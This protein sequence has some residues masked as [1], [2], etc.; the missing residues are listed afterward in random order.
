MRHPLGILC[1]IYAFGCA[2]LAE[3]LST[4]QPA[5]ETMA[6][7]AGIQLPKRPWHMVDLYWEFEKSTTNFESLS[8]DV[9]IDRDIPSTCN[10]YVAPIGLTRINGLDCYGGLQS[11]IT[12]W[13]SKTNQ[14]RHCGGKGAIF[15]RW[16]HDKKTRLSLDYV[17]M[18][19]NGLC[20]SA[21]YEG[22][23]CSVRRPFAWNKGKYTYSIS[24]KETVTDGERKFTWFDCNVIDH[25]KNSTNYIGSLKFEGDTFKL[26]RRN[27]AFVEV[28]QTQWNMKPGIPKCRITF[29]YPLVNGKPPA[30]RETLV[31]YNVPGSRGGSFS[32][33]CVKA[34][35]DGS[36]VI[37]DVGRIFNRPVSNSIER[38][39]LR[40][41]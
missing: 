33:P 24:K 41:K 9:E 10:L 3:E 29:G 39:N 26:W 6:A 28:Y 14:D 13:Q 7:E 35:T 17:R 30:S 40:F 12:G 16:S 5:P 38:L 1:L 18:A 2:A 36:S 27:T 31:S 25:G 34:G 19:E 8:V 4:E 37:F 21:D 15:S 23:F 11:N 32:P 20:E 22:S